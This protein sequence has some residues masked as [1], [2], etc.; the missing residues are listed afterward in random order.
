LLRFLVRK[1]HS[2]DMNE[3][4]IERRQFLGGLAATLAGGA[5]AGCA[6]RLRAESS[7]SAPTA[8]LRTT[9]AEFRAA[10]RYVATPFGRIAYVERGSREAALFLHGFPLNGFQWRG[11]LD[12]LSPLRRCLAPDF[13]A[14]G[15]TEVAEAQ[16]VAP[17]V[18][19]AMLV[20]FLDALSVPTVDLVAS[21]SGGAVAQLFLARHPRRVRT[22]LLTNC[23][24]EVDSPP[25]ALLPVIEMARAGTYADQWLAP[26]LADKALA[27]SSEG[28]G[29]MCYAD[30]GQ[31]TDEAI[32]YYFSPLL[33]SPRRKAQIHAYALALERN[34][35]IGVEASLRESSVPIRIL[36]GTADDIFS[37][38]SP[39]YL[40]RTFGRSRGVRR[41][42][43]RKLFFPEEV[44]EVIAEE[45]RKLW[46]LA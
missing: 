28:I 32:D 2:P 17:E 15:Y 35:L 38:R 26:W 5:L 40:D 10:R 22:L 25:P 9:A 4:R 41:L 27:R 43:G 14:L 7:P 31:P 18:Q 34:P 16:G 46:T 45:A 13:M 3:T 6:S 11:A 23:D 37:P 42:P 21:D 19:V 29:G 44:P 12:L 1:I 33:G 39:E 30:P 36:W 20:A 8:G 24:T